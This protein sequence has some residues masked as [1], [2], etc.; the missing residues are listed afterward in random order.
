MNNR[1]PAIMLKEVNHIFRD[2]RTLLIVFIMPVLQLIIFGYAMNMEVKAVRLAVYDFSNSTG[3]KELIRDFSASKTF[4]ISYPE[5]PV[6]QI[7]QLFF[8]RKYHA[9][10]II[11]QSFELDKI[12]SRKTQV[13]LLIDA[14]D[15]NAA[16]LIKAYCTGV[17]AKYNMVESVSP[18]EVRTNIMYNPD[19]K[20]AYFFVPGLVAMILVM[21]SALLTSIAITRE[22][23]LGTM[24]Q[25]LVS[26]IQG[27]E[28]VIGKVLPYILLA[29]M[30]A[31]FILAIGM[32]LFGV[33]FRG[34][35]AVFSAFTLLYVLTALSLGL[36]ISTIAKSQ[37]AA[38]MMA[39]MITMLPTIM[40]SGFIFPIASMPK[41]LQLITY[42]VPAKYY[43]QII[44]GIMLKG[45][46]FQQLLH[47]MLALCIMTLTMLT[48]AVKRF[49]LRLK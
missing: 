29:L 31:L 25:I 19:M 9:V 42:I 26:P 39:I 36:L 22:K 45:N 20:S 21:I 18:I 13:Q 28:I 41:L 16:T 32:T 14:S 43:L 34:S 44:R 24:E 23:E 6:S 2:S 40:L 33:P 37:Q 4:T 12:H 30:D 5:T 3:S 17:I 46:N 38:M 48:I 49:S 10:L 27:Y 8:T 35:F 15:P 11:P 7:E 47:P 1:I